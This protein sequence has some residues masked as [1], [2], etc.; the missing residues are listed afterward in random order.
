MCGWPPWSAGVWQS[1]IRC[2][3][4]PAVSEKGRSEPL[5]VPNALTSPGVWSLCTRVP[6][7]S[8]P[9]Y[10]DCFVSFGGEKWNLSSFS[11]WLGTT[12]IVDDCD[13]HDDLVTTPQTVG[14]SSQNLGNCWV[15]CHPSNQAL[16]RFSCIYLK[17]PF[18]C[19]FLWLQIHVKLRRQMWELFITHFKWIYFL[20]FNYLAI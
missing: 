7:V 11:Q 9:S 2:P 17:S 20:F 8:T 16:Y 3:P 10:R 19:L 5:R 12:Q 4:P 1:L 6:R 14:S 15:N 18:S 13:R